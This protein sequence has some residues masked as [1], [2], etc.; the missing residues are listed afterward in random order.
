MLRADKYIIENVANAGRLPAVG[1]YI[2]ALPIKIQKWVRS[3]S[4]V[5]W[6]NNIAHNLER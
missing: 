1:A 6:A 2:I 4:K 5:N 3:S